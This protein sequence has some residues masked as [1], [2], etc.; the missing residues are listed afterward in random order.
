MQDLFQTTFDKLRVNW[1]NAKKQ[2]A[3]KESMTDDED[4][5]D[6]DPVTVSSA[7]DPEGS[8]SDDH[9]PIREEMDI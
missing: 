8:E 7:K 4:H 5:G 6:G 1:A 9:D 2:R 3:H